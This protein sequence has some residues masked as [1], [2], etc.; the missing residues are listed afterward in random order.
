M[1]E[2]WFICE[3]FNLMRVLSVGYMYKRLNRESLYIINIGY[4]LL[5]EV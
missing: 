4:I 2:L 3:K 1:N 5:C